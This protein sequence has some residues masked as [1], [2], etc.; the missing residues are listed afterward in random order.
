LDA[1]LS[2]IDEIAFFDSKCPLI[3]ALKNSNES[4]IK[5]LPLHTLK[6]GIF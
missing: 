1:K 4:K 6:K 5:N 2:E 3:G